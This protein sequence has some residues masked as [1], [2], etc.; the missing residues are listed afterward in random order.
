METQAA[1]SASAEAEVRESWL[2]M[3]IVALGQM[4]LSFNTSALPISMGGMV[5]SFDT[6]PTTVATAIVLYSLGVSAF[7]MVGAKF[8]QRF[9]SQ[10]VFQASVL[11]LGATMLV[12]ALSPNAMVMV[13]AQ[14]LAGLAG[15]AL[16]PTLIV[17]IASHYRGNQQAEAVGWV[18]S[19]GAAA[20]VLTFVLGGTLA[21]FLSWRVTFGLGVVHAAVVVLLSFRLKPSECKP[22]VSIDGVGVVLAAASIVLITFGFSNI[23]RW[24]LLLAGANAPFDLLGASPAPVL[25]VFGIALGMAF[26]AWTQRRV[27]MQRTPLLALGV[28]DSPIQWVAVVALCCIGGIEAAI[29]FAVPLYI[30]IVQGRTSLETAAAMM[31]LMLSVVLIAILIVR[32]YERITPRQIARFAFL[33]VTLGTAWLAIVV[34]NEWST[35]PVI[36]G[37]ITVGLGQGA[38]LTLLFSVL[39][40][41]S[42]SELAGDV[43]SLRGVAQNLAAAIGTAVV[44]ALLV[45]L[46][47]SI[48]M[49]HLNENPVITAELKNEVNLSNMNFFSDDQLTQ[50]LASTTATPAQLDEALGINADARTRALKIGFLV[51]SGLALLA[52]VPCSWLPDYTP[53][54]SPSGQASLKGSAT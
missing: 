54:E 7:I 28:I 31:P 38:L 40:T 22:N 45:G 9:G 15:A 18:G 21:T 44:G 25:I 46:L 53:G 42:P 8:G 4:L 26:L 37:L 27:A 30:Q 39:V 19:A 11:A 41:S 52:I 16:V 23:Q 10:R 36:L 3:I 43:G 33:L 2:P 35:V 34:K 17:L 13:A 50:R 6:P 47:S 49:S 51:L 20:A 29:N 1:S 12:M 24:G 48:I 32:L 5:K 14:G